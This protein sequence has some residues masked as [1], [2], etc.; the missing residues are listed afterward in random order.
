MR[1]PKTDPM[2]IVQETLRLAIK[3]CG[4]YTIDH[5]G[6]P[7]TIGPKTAWDFQWTISFTD[8]QVQFAKQITNR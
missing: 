8:I 5:T 7:R 3:A 2:E 6:N 4:P 1:T